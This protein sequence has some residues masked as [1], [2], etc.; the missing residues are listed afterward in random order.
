LRRAD[1]AWA[2]QMGRATKNRKT[3]V[4]IGIV[5]DDEIKDIIDLKSPKDKSKMVKTNN[6]K[7]ILFFFH[8]KLKFQHVNVIIFH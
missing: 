7:Y 5:C 6:F 4:L 2:I 1:D 3:L 8:R